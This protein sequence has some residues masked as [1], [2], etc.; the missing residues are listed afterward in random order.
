MFLKNSF[1]ITS[2]ASLGE[3]GVGKTNILSR[4]TQN[5]FTLESKSTIGIEFATAKSFDIDGKVIKAQ[6]W[7]TGML[8]TLRV[9][10][11]IFLLRQLLWLTTINNNNIW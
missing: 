4:F 1:F 3:S 8:Y 11:Q 10:M 9:V 7:D 5:K 2:I 6:I